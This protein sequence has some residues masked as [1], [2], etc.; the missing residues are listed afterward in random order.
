MVKAFCE[1]YPSPN[2]STNGTSP[3]TQA[4]SHGNLLAT[5]VG[6]EDLDQGQREPPISG[7]A[8]ASITRS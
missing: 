6:E 3:M 2:E 4:S 1:L 8:T 7:I 5:R